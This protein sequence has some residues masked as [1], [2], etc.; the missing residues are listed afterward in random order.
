[1]NRNCNSIVKGSFEILLIVPLSRTKRN[2][3]KMKIYDIKFMCGKL[4]NSGL[5]KGLDSARLQLE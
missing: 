2:G 3:C 1:M 4:G 5:R